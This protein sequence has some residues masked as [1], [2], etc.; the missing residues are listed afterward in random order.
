MPVD[1]LVVEEGVHQEGAEHDQQGRDVAQEVVLDKP[2]PVRLK[3]LHQ[4]HVDL[5]TSDQHP[6][7]SSQ[8]EVVKRGRHH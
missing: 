3:H 8:E 2:R 5:E 6:E 4:Q 1:R 7:E